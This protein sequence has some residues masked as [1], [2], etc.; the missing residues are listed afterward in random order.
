MVYFDHN[1]TTPVDDTVLQAMQPFLATF[2]ANPSS[3]YRAGRITRSAVE[4]AREQVAS[5]VSVQP[6][7]IIFTSGGTEA[8]NLAIKGAVLKNSF[9]GIAVSSVEH[10]SVLESALWMEQH[11]GLVEMVDVDAEG[12]IRPESFE[13]VCADSID[14]IS[15]MLANN[16]TGTIQDVAEFSAAAH[17]R[18]IL[19]HTDAVQA[20]GKILVDFNRLGVDSMTLSSHKIYGPKGVG[21]LV[22]DKTLALNPI[23]SGG[24]QENG[25]RGGTENVAAIVGF[26]KAAELA[27]SQ[28][29]QRSEHLLELKKQLEA[30]LEKIAGLVIFAKEVCR[31][32]NTV[33]FGVPGVDGEMLL[34]QLDRKGVAVSSGSA[35]SSGGGEPSHVLMAMGVDESL[36]KSAIRV[37]LG[38]AN[39]F[40]E[41]NKFIEILNSV[42]SVPS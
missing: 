36:A 15:V 31:L 34:M 20:A 4:T 35:C 13:K 28:I 8:N 6:P 26:G 22:V 21:A 5:L 27:R 30:E 10:P 7:Q 1:A 3:L 39:T 17:E 2:F 38:Q 29:E 32:P 37:S 40:S 25:F 19:F 9:P 18:K 16:E 41:V 23:I 24:G 33:Q 11:G 42:V 12:R 14:L